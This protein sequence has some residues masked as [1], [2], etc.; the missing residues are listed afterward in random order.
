MCVLRSASRE[1]RRSC[2]LGWCRFDLVMVMLGT[3]ATTID[4]E[5][6]GD[7][8]D[9]DRNG[10]LEYGCE[11]VN[12]IQTTQLEDYTNGYTINREELVRSKEETK[13]KGDNNKQW[14]PVMNEL[15]EFDYL[16][17]HEQPDDTAHQQESAPD[18][19]SKWFHIVY[20][21]LRNPRDVG[22]EGLIS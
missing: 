12:N 3:S 9:R 16:E 18:D 1:A 2:F 8:D 15:R 10:N 21:Y 11:V 14:P 20:S 4:D 13:G 17:F 7:E 22:P 6:Q 19:V 5:M